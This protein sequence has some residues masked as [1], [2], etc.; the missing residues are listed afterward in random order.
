MPAWSFLCLVALTTAAA[1][2]FLALLSLPLPYTCARPHLPCILT[3]LA[4]YRS[5]VVGS[6]HA[7]LHTR[8]PFAGPT[9]DEDC[10]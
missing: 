9:D 5:H 2:C 10:Y 1:A 8:F 7:D 6:L 4:C 3:F